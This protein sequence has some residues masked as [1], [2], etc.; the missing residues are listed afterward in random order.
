MNTDDKTA[1]DKECSI[2]VM[3]VINNDNILY[4]LC[5]LFVTGQ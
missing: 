4:Y 2:D 3:C 1:S 5:V